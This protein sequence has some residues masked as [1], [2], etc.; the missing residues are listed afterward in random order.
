MHASTDN[1]TASRSGQTPDPTHPSASNLVAIW[2]RGRR[3]FT[4][5]AY[6]RLRALAAVRFT[7]GLFLVGLGA[8]MLSHGYRGWAAVVPLAGAAL[9][10]SIASLDFTVARSASHRT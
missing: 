6:P 7:A 2:A 5:W 3:Q 9:L 10:F 8:V 4:P 1:T